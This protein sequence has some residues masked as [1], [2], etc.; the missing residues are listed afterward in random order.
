[1]NSQLPIPNTNL[2]KYLYGN[3]Y[4]EALEAEKKSAARQGFFRDIGRG[5]RTQLS[6]NRRYTGVENINLKKILLNKQF[7]NKYASDKIKYIKEKINNFL[8]I[9]NESKNF[10]LNLLKHY[11]RLLKLQHYLKKS[12]S[13]GDSI[14]PRY[15]FFKFNNNEFSL[16]VRDNLY[17]I[18]INE[19]NNSLLLT[20]D[21]IDKNKDETSFIKESLYY[22]D[23]LMFLLNTNI[24][25]GYTKDVFDKIRK[26]PSKI[27]DFN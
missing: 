17:S 9:G 13:F 11:I 25:L 5:I 6:R 27:Y 26:I 20:K 16:P 2:F 8:K 4:I 14:E 10:K 15:E 12:H 21:Y 19:L 23:K 24:Y 1:M 22:K 3:K 7:V 18:L